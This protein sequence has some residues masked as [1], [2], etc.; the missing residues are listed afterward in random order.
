MK[1]WK[2]S[3]NFVKENYRI[4][5][6]V[7]FIMLF[8]VSIDSFLYEGVDPSVKFRWV[9]VYFPAWYDIAEWRVIWVN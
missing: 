8:I 1:F 5:T 6:V 4:M 9:S 3:G 2:V 7:I